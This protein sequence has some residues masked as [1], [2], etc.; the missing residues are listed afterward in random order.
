MATRY[1][2]SIQH[3]TNA[4]RNKKT[5]KINNRARTVPSHLRVG[6]EPQVPDSIGIRYFFF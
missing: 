1:M 6:K 5:I 3:P 2:Y 4:Y